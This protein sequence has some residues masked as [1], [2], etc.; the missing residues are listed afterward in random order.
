MPDWPAT[1]RE[2]PVLAY[3]AAGCAI[4]IAIMEW[5]ST[6]AGEP[7]SRVPFVT[8]IVLVMMLPRS[9]AA[10]PF[11]VLVGHASACLAGFAALWLAGAGAA[12]SAVGVGLAGFLML[13][14]KAPHPPAGIDAFLI[15]GHGLPLAWLL[16]PVLAGCILLVVFAQAWRWGERA[17]FSSHKDREP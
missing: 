1:L 17:L 5:L 4:A 13:L 11:A 8:S 10:Q 16:S 7:L 14:L 12:A 9:E 15:A 3:R 6:Y 2:L